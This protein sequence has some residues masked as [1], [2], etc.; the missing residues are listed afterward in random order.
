MC[1]CVDCTLHTPTIQPP[2]IPHAPTIH[3]PYIPHTSSIHPH[4][5]SSH[6]TSPSPTLSHPP[7]IL[8]HPLSPPMLSCALTTLMLSCALTSL[9]LTSPH[10]LISPHLT[11]DMSCS[12]RSCTSPPWWFSPPANGMCLIPRLAVGL[13]LCSGVRAPHCT[14]TCVQCN[15]VG[16]AKSNQAVNCK[17]AVPARVMLI[18]HRRDGPPTGASAQPLPCAG[19]SRRLAYK[20]KSTA[21]LA[22]DSR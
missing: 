11:R 3:P 12:N 10:L 2:Y 8:S 1:T 15:A 21:L 18:G 5:T 6:L 20:A 4:V 17:F 22:G 7:D 19:N 16:G 13:D 9:H 14:T